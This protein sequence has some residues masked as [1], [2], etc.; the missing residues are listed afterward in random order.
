MEHN[1]ADTDHPWHIPSIIWIAGV[2]LLVGLLAII[3][4]NVPASTV[5][6]LSFIALMFGSHLLPGGH[7][8]H[9]NSYGQQSN[10]S[11]D[12]SDQVYATQ[13]VKADQTNHRRGCH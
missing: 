11:S 2:G 13:P 12:A 4:F 8:N 3:F 5:V 7:G 1:H 6:F 10:P 9:G